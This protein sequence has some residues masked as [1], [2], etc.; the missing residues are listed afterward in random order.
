MTVAQ[1]LEALSQ[2]L[3]QVN[4]NLDKKK[5]EKE[6]YEKLLHTYM[7]ALNVGNFDLQY[8]GLVQALAKET[9]KRLADNSSRAWMRGVITKAPTIY[10]NIAVTLQLYQ[11]LFTQRKELIESQL[12]GLSDTINTYQTNLQNLGIQ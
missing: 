10:G 5:V 6:G 9:N 3:G 12:V 8:F 7:A 4:K 11:T 1:E 2:Y